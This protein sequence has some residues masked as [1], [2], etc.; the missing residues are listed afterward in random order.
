VLTK[1]A[2]TVSGQPGLGGGYTL[3]KKPSANCLLDIAA[4]FKQTEPPSL[5]PFGHDWCGISDPCLLHDTVL[6]RIERNRSFMQKNHTIDFCLQETDIW[7]KGRELNLQ[8]T[9]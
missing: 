5:C 1:Q 6:G 8:Q 2:S 3:A 7:K 9:S 4:L